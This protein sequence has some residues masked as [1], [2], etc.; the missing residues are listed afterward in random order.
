MSASFDPGNDFADVTDGLELVTLRRPGTSILVSDIH[1]LPRAAHLVSVERSDGQYATHD[2][3]WHLPAGQLPV[4]PQPGDVLVAADDCCWTVL[5]A[6]KATLA[7]RWRC[8]CRNLAAL[9]GLDL[10][11]DIQQASYHKDDHGQEQIAWHTWRA[12]LRAKIQPNTAKTT[13]THDHPATVARYRIYCAE[14]LDLNHH[15]RIRGPDGTTYQVLGMTKA[16]RI[17]ALL[18]IDAVKTP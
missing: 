18:E 4:A 5:T 2:V 8:V 11:I 10:Y 1:A 9:H 17:D 3:V 14:D 16:Q 6:Q 15:H 13:D 7:S 12:G